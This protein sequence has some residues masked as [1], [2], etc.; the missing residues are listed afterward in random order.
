MTPRSLT[1]RLNAATRHTQQRSSARCAAALARGLAATST[2]HTTRQGR[3]GRAGAG[4][5]AARQG[6]P[7]AGAGLGISNSEIICSPDVHLLLTLRSPFVNLDAIGSAQWFKQ[8]GLN[9]D[10]KGNK[11]EP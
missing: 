4:N 11:N 1:Y 3:Q 8:L 6:K 2:L 7:S 5:R 9:L 10:W